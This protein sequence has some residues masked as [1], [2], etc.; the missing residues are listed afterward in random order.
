MQKV[1]QSASG[2][3]AKLG[4]RRKTF[5][6]FLPRHLSFQ[7]TDLS[8]GALSFLFHLCPCHLSFT[9]PSSKTARASNTF[10]SARPPRFNISRNRPNIALSFSHPVPS[11]SGLPSPVFASIFLVILVFFRGYSFSL[12][13]PTATAI[14]AIR[15]I[16]EI[17]G[18]SPLSSPSA[19]S[20]QPY[21]SL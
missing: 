16:R 19:T 20:F 3:G 1:I 15:V 21:V 12:S 18:H 13:S 10:S 9:T 6:F 17:R 4:S 2:P 7:P 5:V 8:F 14:A 11:R